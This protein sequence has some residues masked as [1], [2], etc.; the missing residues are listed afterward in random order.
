MSREIKFRAW[1][2]KRKRYAK[3]IQT[4]NQGWKGYRDKTYITNGVMVFSKWVLSRFIIEQHTGLKD[5]N[6]KEIYEG[7][8]LTW[9][10]GFDE[11]HVFRVEWQGNR[12]KFC[13]RNP[14]DHWDYEEINDKKQPYMVV[15]GNVHDNQELLGGEE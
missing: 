5:K 6:G 13:L 15:I 11:K 4:T 1:D 3:A 7:D 12:A 10:D 14:G 2:K 9:T 8:I